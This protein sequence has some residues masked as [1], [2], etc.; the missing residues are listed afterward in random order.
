MSSKSYEGQ[1]D[2]RMGVDL[3]TMIGEH[4]NRLKTAEVVARK[5]LKEIVAS[6]DSIKAAEVELVDGSLMVTLAFK[7]EVD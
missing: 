4:E 7:V 2:D 1:F 6:E 5:A 3:G